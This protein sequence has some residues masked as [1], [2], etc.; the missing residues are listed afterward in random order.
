MINEIS[1]INTSG[2]WMSVNMKSM[3]LSRRNTVRWVPLIE[4][5]HTYLEVE[6]AAYLKILAY[7]YLHYFHSFHLSSLFYCCFFSFLIFLSNLLMK[8]LTNISIPSF[9][10]I[11]KLDYILFSSVIFFFFLLYFTLFNRGSINLTSTEGGG[12]LGIVQ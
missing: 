9:L 6:G 12:T 1:K 3:P 8:K 4:R 11:V 2:P 5:R 7:Y 10:F